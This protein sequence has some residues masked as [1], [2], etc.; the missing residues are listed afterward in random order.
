MTGPNVFPKRRSPKVRSFSRE[1]DP[2]DPTVERVRI[3]LSL[4]PARNDLD[5]SGEPCIV[6]DVVFN[7]DVMQQAL[8]AKEFKDFLVGLG[9]GWV[10]EKGGGGLDVQNHTEVKLRGNY[11]GKFP[12]MQ[13]VRAEALIEEVDPIDEGGHSGSGSRYSSLLALLVHK[14]KN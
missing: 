1:P 8:H 7:T 10:M 5:K 13:V 11:K 3:P 6:Y 4:G 2:N 9:M 14:N 12:A